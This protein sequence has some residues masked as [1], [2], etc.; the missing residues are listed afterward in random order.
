MNG[1]GEFQYSDGQKYKGYY[2]NGLK[3]G[4]G[5]YNTQNMSKTFAGFWNKGK[6]DGIGCL[7]SKNSIKYGLWKNGLRVKWFQN[8]PEIYKYMNQEELRYIN[9]FK[10]S[11]KE[12]I[13]L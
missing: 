1:Y 10:N 6:Q 9:M 3:E 8:K 2:I 7:C 11:H 13:E 5:I 12:F 4:F